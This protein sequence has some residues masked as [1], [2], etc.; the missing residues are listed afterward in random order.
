MSSDNHIKLGILKYSP[1]PSIS[2]L[3]HRIFMEKLGVD[4]SYESFSVS[5]SELEEFMSGDEIASLNGFNVTI[6]HK[7]SITG[8][9]HS[10]TPE[11][12]AVGAVNTVAVRE[13]KNIGHNTDTTGFKKAVEM[14]ELELTGNDILLFGAGG[15]AR[16]VVFTLGNL[17]VS[18][19]YVRNRSRTHALAL[20]ELLSSSTNETE[21]VVLDE[22]DE[23]PSSPKILFNALGGGVFVANWLENLSDLNFFF[24]L[25]YGKNAFDKTLL[26]EGVG[27]SDGLSMLVY[28]GIES[29]KFWLDKEIPDDGLTESVITELNGEILI[30]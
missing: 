23:I 29:L 26:N 16:A 24:D 7:Q 21:L 4:G 9:M 11:G 5:P 28:Q 3:M 22:S 2:P 13:G 20:S 19:I 6:P 10:L 14:L 18:K 12:K 8:F 25:N 15:A 27:Y 30:G 1:T 17:G